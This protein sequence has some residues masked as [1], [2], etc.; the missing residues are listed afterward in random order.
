VLWR[1]PLSLA[2]QIEPTDVAVIV[3]ASIVIA[4]V[5]HSARDSV[6]VAMIM[7]ATN[8]AVGGGYASQLFHGRDLVLLGLVTAIAWRG[9]AAVVLARQRTIRLP[10]RPARPTVGE[11]DDKGRRAT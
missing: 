8:N 4:A 9:V 1:L 5:F 10:N 3:P 2:G 11:E 6:L 7:H